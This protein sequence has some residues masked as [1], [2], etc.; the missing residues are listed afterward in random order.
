MSSL[1]PVAPSLSGKG[2]KKLRD[3]NEPFLT[4]SRAT[5]HNA[6]CQGIQ[7]RSHRAHD[8]W[9]ES[10]YDFSAPFLKP[11]TAQ[12]G[13]RSQTPHTRTSPSVHTF[14]SSP[15]GLVSE[16]SREANKWTCRHSNCASSL[17]TQSSS[18]LITSSFPV[19]VHACA[20]VCGIGIW[21]LLSVN[22]SCLCGTHVGRRRHSCALRSDL[23][24]ASLGPDP[25]PRLDSPVSKQ[26]EEVGHLPQSGHVRIEA[27]ASSHLQ[28]PLLPHETSIYWKLL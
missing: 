2:S 6:P 24:G 22:L 20:G 21:I 12:T 17:T 4:S 14:A 5:P 23:C 28:K 27:H 9:I 8:P 11:Q 7:H 26:S 1:H 19:H 10:S 25:L 16:T 18:L 15:S 3:P 13:L